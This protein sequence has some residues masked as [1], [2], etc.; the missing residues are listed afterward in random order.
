LIWYYVLRR[1]L[2]LPVIVF[3]VTLILFSLP[4]QLPVELR[5]RTDNSQTNRILLANVPPKVFVFSPW[6]LGKSG[7]PRLGLHAERLT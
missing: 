4:W 3:L 1:L 2:V 5:A 6:P 7:P